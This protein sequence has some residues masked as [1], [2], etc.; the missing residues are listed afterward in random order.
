MKNDITWL[1]TLML[2]LMPLFFSCGS[3]V[4]EVVGIRF[5][6]EKLTLIVGKDERGSWV[7]QLPL[8]IDTNNR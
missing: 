3:S 6:R 4:P 7:L 2:A 5:N 8:E 1:A